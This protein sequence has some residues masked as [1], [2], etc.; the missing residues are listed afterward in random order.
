[1]SHR[2]PTLHTSDYKFDPHD[3][4]FER[5]LRRERFQSVAEW[6]I[7]RAVPWR[8]RLAA[9]LRQRADRPRPATEADGPSR[10]PRR[11]PLQSG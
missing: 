2:R 11:G 4:F 3:P 10:L 8:E 9:L 7:G 5:D 6:I 1:M